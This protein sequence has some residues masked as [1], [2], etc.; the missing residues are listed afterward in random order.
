MNKAIITVDNRAIYIY[1]D[2]YKNSYE[3]YVDG[4]KTDEWVNTDTFVNAQRYAM[5][6]L[7]T[8]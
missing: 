7:N 3:L 6:L 8:K 5:E 1:N 2:G 4:K